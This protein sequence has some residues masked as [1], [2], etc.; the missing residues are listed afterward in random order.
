MSDR[1]RR[2]V[3]VELFRASVPSGDQP[4]QVVADDRVLRRL[5]DRGQLRSR[6]LAILAFG[7]IDK[8]DNGAIDHVVESTVGPD[9]H[10]VAGS[11]QDRDLAFQGRQR[12]EHLPHVVR[13]TIPGQ[14][15]DDVADR[16]T[17]VSLAHIEDFKQAR[18][19]APDTKIVIEEQCR[20]RCAVEQIAQVTVQPHQ[21]I[22][23]IAEL[24]IDRLQ[25][26]VQ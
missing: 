3:A 22:V 2:P 10:Q 5:Y 6:L 23:A 11:V 20:D 24:G 21:A 13:Q 4:I 8:G 16:A 9:L 18:R 7:N 19:E 1:L 15:R 12:P 25:L 17:L 14:T 26:L